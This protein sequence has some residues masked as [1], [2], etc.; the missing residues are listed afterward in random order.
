M[1]MDS[2]RKTRG[3][4]STITFSGLCWT[5]AVFSGFA[6]IFSLAVVP[7]GF[8]ALQTSVDFSGPNMFERIERNPADFERVLSGLHESRINLFGLMHASLSGYSR[9]L[10]AAAVLLV[11]A[12][13]LL[14]TKYRSRTRLFRVAIPLSAGGGALALALRM[15]VIKGRETLPPL[16]T[17]METVGTLEPTGLQ[18]ALMISAESLRSNLFVSLEII[19]VLAIVSVWLFVI[20]SKLARRAPAAGNDGV[21]NAELA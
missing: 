13:A 17:F 11:V 3:A 6:I 15:F 12:R 16:Q 1:E 20:L 21:N 8:V 9:F 2:E 10:L 4:V 19:V 5:A 7:T 18:E 14:P